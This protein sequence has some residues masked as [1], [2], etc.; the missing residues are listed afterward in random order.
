[1]AKKAQQNKTS[2][3][4]VG[5][6]QGAVDKWFAD[7]LHNSVV[8]RDTAVHNL[9]HDAKPALVAAVVAAVGQTSTSE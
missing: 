4:L 5:K 9:I 7:N 3:V 2:D 8:S 6:V 1:M